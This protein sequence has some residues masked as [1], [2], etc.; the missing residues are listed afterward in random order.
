MLSLV[1]LSLVL[2]EFNDA[3]SE[4]DGMDRMQ[5][6]IKSGRFQSKQ[7]LNSLDENEFGGL[8]GNNRFR[9]YKRILDAIE[10]D[11]FGLRKRALDALEGEG[12]GLKKRA[13]DELEGGGFGLKK[14]ALDSLE[15]AGFGLKKRALDA[16]EGEGFGLKKRGLDE[17][18]GEGFGMAKRI[19]S[20]MQGTEYGMRTKVE[21][22]GFDRMQKHP[23]QSSGLKDSVLI[24]IP[25][26]EDI[27]IR[28]GCSFPPVIF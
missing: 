1:L 2:G 27:H 28:T 18:D 16:L 5:D 21:N 14:R 17:L 7:T 9:I 19:L 24:V 8:E 26:M 12:F 25:Q 10:G 22:E 3:K 13:L 15:G 20:T 6:F 11:G 4:F 23:S